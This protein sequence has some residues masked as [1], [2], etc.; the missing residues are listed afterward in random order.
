MSTKILKINKI[1]ICSKYIL[2][3]IYVGVPLLITIK[4]TFVDF[5]SF[6]NNIL[7]NILF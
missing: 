7:L 6:D 3:R 2:R 5:I 4:S 1:I